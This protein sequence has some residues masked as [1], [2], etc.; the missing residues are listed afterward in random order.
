MPAFRVSS[1]TLG[2]LDVEAANWLVA[3][4]H[5]LDRL[6]IDH[7]PDRIACE[8]LHNGTVLVRDVRTGAGF[9]VQPLDPPEPEPMSDEPD[10][11]IDTLV[12]PEESDDD[13]DLADIE[14]EDMAPTS[15]VVS[16]AADSIARAMDVEA[17]LAIAVAAG[18]RLTQARAGSALL[19]EPAGLRFRY[20]SGEHASRLRGMRI[21]HGAGVAGFSVAHQTALI[22]QNAY[23]DPRFYRNVDKHTGHL[24]RSLLCAP[25][26]TAG[27]SLGCIEF[28]DSTRNGGFLD[29][30]LAE[31]LFVATAAANRIGS[32]ATS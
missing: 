28:V 24:T 8:R 26:V 10:E 6:G 2:S 32:L 21:P 9:S 12:P 29:D 20:V 30:E 4:G 18:V 14:T 19:V 13:A 27:T 22:V 31:V 11:A 16:V 7:S 17:T 5:G 23:N 3:L 1:R 25:L 15:H